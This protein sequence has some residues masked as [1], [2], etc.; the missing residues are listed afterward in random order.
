MLSK[1][2][3]YPKKLLVMTRLSNCTENQIDYLSSVIPDIIS[4]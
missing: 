3:S 4:A 2:Y 1:N